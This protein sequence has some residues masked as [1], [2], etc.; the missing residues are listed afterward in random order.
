MNKVIISPVSRVIKPG[1]LFRHYKG[2]HYK[3]TNVSTHTETLEQLV[4]YHNID[5]PNESWARPLDM[6][7]DCMI[8]DNKYQLRF[9]LITDDNND[10][11]DNDNPN[12]N[13]E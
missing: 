4:V 13:Q 2:A 1:D 8:I 3:V 5:K 12:S 9:V 11:N 6:F 7:N 10:N